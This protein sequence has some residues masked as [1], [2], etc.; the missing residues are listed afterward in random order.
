MVIFVQE[1]RKTVKLTAQNKIHQIA[2]G[3]ASLDPHPTNLFCIQIIP[4]GLKTDPITKVALK[5]TMQ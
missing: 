2:I 1:S 3:Y 4:T 5:E